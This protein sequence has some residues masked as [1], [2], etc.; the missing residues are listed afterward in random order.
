M[1]SNSHN[2]HQGS[3]CIFS[4][5]IISS[6]LLS[7]SPFLYASNNANIDTIQKAYLTGQYEKC[8]QSARNGTLGSI[9]E[10]R[11]ILLV[12]SLMA[13][14]K[15]PEAARELDTARLSEPLSLRLLM[16]GYEVNL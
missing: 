9:S 2:D 7:F 4:C 10:E 11:G 12:K 15:Y 13:L 14:G 5:L 1:A 8:V 16:L 3:K 6:V